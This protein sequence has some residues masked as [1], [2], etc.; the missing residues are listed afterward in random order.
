MSAS[1]RYNPR[2][3]W[4]FLLWLLSGC[5]DAPRAAPARLIGAMGGAVDRVVWVFGGESPLGPSAEVWALD[6]AG[7]RW[8]RYPDMPQPRV[9]GTAVYD[10][11]G[12]FIVVGG[13]SDS[14]EASVIRFDLASQAWTA[15]ASPMPE[16]TYAGLTLTDDGVR[17]IGG[18]GAS[19]EPLAD[20]WTY[21]EG[22][23][24]A[25]PAPL[26]GHTA[27]HTADGTVFSVAA[28]HLSTWGEDAP[29]SVQLPSA[30][31]APACVWGEATSL[32]I[33]QSR[34]LWQADLGVLHSVELL[35]NP[36]PDSAL[37]A[38]IDSTLWT[39]GG[40]HDGEP[41]NEVWRFNS[42]IWELQMRGSEPVAD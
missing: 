19:G 28:G 9:A 33:W 18:L 29:T 26:A 6:V 32:W 10:G 15:L 12:G 27:A 2:V 8:Q 25:S 42:G 39:F 1:A 36:P 20:V 24:T 41:S 22:W 16:R 13:V 34:Q 31:D 3:R 23:T 38:A 4:T 5:G 7:Q 21:R 37:C 30:E 40:A 11:D 35:A 14:A 17:L